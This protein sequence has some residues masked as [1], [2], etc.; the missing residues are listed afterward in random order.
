[1]RLSAL[2]VMGG[3]KLDSYYCIDAPAPAGGLTFNPHVVLSIGGES[4]VN[5]DYP[6]RSDINGCYDNDLECVFR[7]HVSRSAPPETE[8]QY[9][10]A[11]R[12][13][14][15]GSHPRTS[16]RRSRAA[17]RQRRT[18]PGRRGTRR[19]CYGFRSDEQPQVSIP[20]QT[21]DPTGQ[22]VDQ[23]PD[24]HTRGAVEHDVYG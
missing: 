22:L 17:A 5:S 7:R 20:A 19:Y 1:M 4:S 18:S 8:I 24:R 15:F 11:Q 14:P 13:I 16:Q 10:G 21:P 2:S 9:R 23:I 12:S 3:A 6:R